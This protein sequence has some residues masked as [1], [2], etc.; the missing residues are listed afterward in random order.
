MASQV[1]IKSRPRSQGIPK[2]LSGSTSF[3]KETPKKTVSKTRARTL[4]S[5]SRARTSQLPVPVPNVNKADKTRRKADVQSKK[6]PSSTPSTSAAH[7]LDMDISNQSQPGHTNSGQDEPKD[8]PLETS[9]PSQT[10]VME[11]VNREEAPL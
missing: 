3:S 6:K 9:A 4:R 2:R 8:P 10:M 11:D 5:S 1:K 7:T